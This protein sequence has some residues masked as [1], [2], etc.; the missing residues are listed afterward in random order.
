GS[1]RLCFSSSSMRTTRTPPS[2]V[3][4][5]MAKLARVIIHDVQHAK[6]LSRAECVGQSPALAKDVD[7]KEDYFDF[8]IDFLGLAGYFDRQFRRTEGCGLELD[9]TSE[10]A[11][12]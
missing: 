7:A 1:P 3:S 2:E 6:P 8:L 4:T 9:F 10:G 12:T 5:S 11:S